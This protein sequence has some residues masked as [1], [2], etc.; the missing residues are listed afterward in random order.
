[1]ITLQVLLMLNMVVSFHT[2]WEYRHLDRQQEFSTGRRLP[3]G[4]IVKG[5]VTPRA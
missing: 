4:F 3:V 2:R 5:S 1:M